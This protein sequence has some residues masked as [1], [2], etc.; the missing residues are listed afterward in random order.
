MKNTANPC[1]TS[2]SNDCGLGVVSLLIRYGE[3][4]SFKVRFIQNL[5]SLRAARFRHIRI[6][7]GDQARAEIDSATSN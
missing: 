3:G 1:G 4:M 6:D 5:S 7:P 2:Q